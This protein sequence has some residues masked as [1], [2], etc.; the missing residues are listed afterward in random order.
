M[1]AGGR[2]RVERHD[3][4]RVRSEQFV[5]IEPDFKPS[6]VDAFQDDGLGRDAKLAGIKIALDAI[7]FVFES[8]NVPV[9]FR[10]PRRLLT[11]CPISQDDSEFR[12]TATRAAVGACGASEWCNG[13]ETPWL[14][15]L[16]Y[17]AFGPRTWHCQGNAPGYFPT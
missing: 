2:I 1:V 7:K 10:L 17:P 14:P 12:Q 11:R 5:P 16:P 8:H 6:K 4:I 15:R 9:D 3:A 13:P